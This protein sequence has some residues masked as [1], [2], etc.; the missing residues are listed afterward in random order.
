VTTAAEKLTKV[1]KEEEEIKE[2]KK[3]FI[4]ELKKK[5]KNKRKNNLPY[6]T[7]IGFLKQ[8]II[9]AQKNTET[10]KD[11]LYKAKMENNKATVVVD[12]S[13]LIF[14]TLH[15]YVDKIKYI[16]IS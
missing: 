14:N 3:Q 15:E 9:N 4:I 5:Q 8:E 16:I 11:E 2:E 1:T 10:A 13:Q 12:M 6:D 7:P